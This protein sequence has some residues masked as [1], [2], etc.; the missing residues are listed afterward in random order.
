LIGVIIDS[1]I[2]PSRELRLLSHEIAKGLVESGRIGQLNPEGGA[3]S[4]LRLLKGD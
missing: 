1:W 3:D 4:R 2:N